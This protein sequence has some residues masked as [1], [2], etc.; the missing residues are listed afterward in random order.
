MLDMVERFRPSGLVHLH[1]DRRR[2]RPT[3][4]AT[5]FEILGGFFHHGLWMWAIVG[6]VTGGV[7]EGLVHARLRPQLSR[8]RH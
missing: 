8:D 5:I 1:V 3:V 6:F 7:A 4:Q 2:Q